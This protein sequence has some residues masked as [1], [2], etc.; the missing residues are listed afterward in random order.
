MLSNLK[1]FF[2]SHSNA[3]ILSVIIILG[4][5][6]VIGAGILYQKELSK[7]PIEIEEVE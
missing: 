4:L 5:L 7:P 1:N 3:V 6:L 2:K